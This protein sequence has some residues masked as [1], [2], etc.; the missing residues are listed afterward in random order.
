MNKL[1][2]KLRY[3]HQKTRIAIYTIIA[4]IFALLNLIGY[5]AFLESQISG[6]ALI[7]IGIVGAL[8]S[9]AKVYNL[10]KTLGV[11]K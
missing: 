9:M 2:K 3:M 5:Y 7:V 10:S 8:F 1:E 11:F 4:I 6:M